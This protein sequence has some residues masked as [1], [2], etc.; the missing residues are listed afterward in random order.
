MVCFEKWQSIRP[1][2]PLSAPR[3]SATTVEVV[4][5]MM[6]MIRKPLS[7]VVLIVLLFASARRYTLLGVIF[8]IHEFRH[9]SSQNKAD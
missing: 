2:S 3:V 5:I 9:S 7:W 8:L 6:M 1:L 4:M